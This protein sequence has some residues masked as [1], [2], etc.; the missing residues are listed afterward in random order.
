MK[1]RIIAYHILK[2]NMQKLNLAVKVKLDGYRI[3]KKLIFPE[4]LPII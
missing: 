4:Y 2:I 1:S 3:H